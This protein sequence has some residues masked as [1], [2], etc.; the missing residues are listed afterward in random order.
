[1]PALVATAGEHRPLTRGGVA[2]GGSPRQPHERRQRH[3]A[4]DPCCRHQRAGSGAQPPPP[5]AQAVDRGRQAE[6]EQRFGIDDAEE[7]GER[8][9]EGQEG[10]VPGTIGRQVE[11]RR[12]VDQ[13]GGGHRRHP[14]HDDAGEVEVGLRA[15]EQPADDAHQPRVGGEERQVV[16]SAF[17]PLIAAGGD[18]V[19]P[20]RV[21]AGEGIP[22][23]VRGAEHRE[24]LA[25]IER[26]GHVDE[27]RDQRRRDTQRHDQQHQVGHGA[28]V[29]GR[30]GS[31]T[32]RCRHRAHC[33]A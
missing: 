31:W 32:D 4:V 1:M 26:E 11:A 33:S 13:A 9:D 8:E 5:G 30:P 7:E 3:H 29:G 17:H 10:R 21:V 12:G 19:V 25:L 20:A 18:A 16:A 14:R 15:A 23:V 2:V 24:L 27:E 28:R 22:E 6:Q